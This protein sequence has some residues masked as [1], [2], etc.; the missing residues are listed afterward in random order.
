MQMSLINEKV[1]NLESKLYTVEAVGKQKWSA[2]DEK[3]ESLQLRLNNILNNSSSEIINRLDT[4]E[5][6]IVKLEESFTNLQESQSL[7]STK[8]EQLNETFKNAQLFSEIFPF[9]PIKNF[10]SYLVIPGTSDYETGKKTC[11]KLNSHLLDFTN[12]NYQEKLFDVITVLD[13]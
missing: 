5:D 1:H 2:V 13:L 4:F 8:L 11:V 10:G 7:T 9:T 6:K 12:E 3:L